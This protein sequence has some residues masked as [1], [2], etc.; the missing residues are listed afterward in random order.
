MVLRL[1]LLALLL[2]HCF[3]ILYYFTVSCFFT[4]RTTFQ[5]C[6][7]KTVEKI[8]FSSLEVSEWVGL[9]VS[10]AASVFTAFISS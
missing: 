10:G 5:L 1:L 2:S 8:P 4:R 6:L 7:P 3:I 9:T